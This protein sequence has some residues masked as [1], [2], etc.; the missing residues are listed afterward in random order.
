MLPSISLSSESVSLLRVRGL[1]VQQVDDFSEL[2]NKAHQQQSQDRSAKQVLAE[3]SGDELALLQ[4]ATS[5]A[6]NINVSSLSNEGAIN[7][8]AQPDK[9]GMVDLNNDG[10][11][12]IG[13][14]KMVT[15]PPV[16][17]PDSVHQAWDK[18]TENM[19]EGDKMIMQLHM[20]TTV[21][22]FQ[23][24]G[25]PTK[26]PI[27]PEAQWSETGWQ[28]LLATLRSAL[29]FSVGIDGWTRMNVVRQDFYDRFEG[30]LR[31]S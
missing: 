17:A 27:S 29:E 28:Q 13:I 30:E 25:L 23:I 9:T 3:M 31:H 2:L 10:V 5:L 6:S 8:L 11:V 19:A 12:E 1:S 22:G 15:F 4:K 14:A 21:Y 7:L 20:H 26:E 24:E 16:N 18:A